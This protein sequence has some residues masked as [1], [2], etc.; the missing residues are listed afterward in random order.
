MTLTLRELTENDEQAFFEGAKL[1][2]GEAPYWYSFAW[3]PRMSFQEMLTILKKEKAGIDLA[4]G[5]VPHTM[6]YGFVDGKIIG[7][8]S[9]RHELNESL[10]KRGGHI[11]YAVA[12]IYRRKGLATEMVRQALEYC[13]TLNISP[14]MVSCADHNTGSWK[15]VE[16]FGGKLE[17]KVWDDQDK[18]MIR[19][20]WI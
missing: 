10:R 3:K 7:R 8:V 20:Y 2:T 16:H 11:G 13:R 19:R 9:I 1:W 6:L 12:P 15:I 5:R 17:D 18:E 14:V 4:P